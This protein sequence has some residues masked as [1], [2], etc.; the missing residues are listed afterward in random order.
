MPTKEEFLRTKTFKE[1]GIDLSRRVFYTLQ[2][3]PKSLQ[4]H[5][6]SLAIAMLVEHLH[7]NNLISD[8]EVDTLLMGL[9]G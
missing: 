8:N 3:E 7:K 4:P 9:V 2:Q 5:R 6:N 1:D